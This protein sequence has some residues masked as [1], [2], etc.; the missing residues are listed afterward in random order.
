[1][2][3]KIREEC[4]TCQHWVLGDQVLTTDITNT[5]NCVFMTTQE[6]GF[7]DKPQHVPFW[8]KNLLHRTVSWEGTGCPVYELRKTTS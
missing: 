3:K 6:A 4:E 7:Y 2:S 1:M 8:A 5:G